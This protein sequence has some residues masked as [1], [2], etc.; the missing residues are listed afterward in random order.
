MNI[1]EGSAI[2]WKRFDRFWRIDAL[3]VTGLKK[4]KAD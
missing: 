1:G 2:F 3:G 4:Q